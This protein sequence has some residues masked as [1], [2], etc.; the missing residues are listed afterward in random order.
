MAVSRAEIQ[1]GISLQQT[2]DQARAAFAFQR[3]KEVRDKG[4][5]ELRKGY[6]SHVEKLPAMIQTNGLGQTL[7]FLYSKGTEDARFVP[8]KKAEAR[9][10]Q[11]LRE[12][13]CQEEWPIGPYSEPVEGEDSDEELKLLCRL[14]HCDS[15]VYRRAT[16]EALALV[17]WLKRFAGGMLEKGE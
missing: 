10:Y 7:A 15:Q 1:A 3:M 9:L 4:G 6:R 13:L 8:D 2:L 5:P 12:W 14:T 17:S 16:V 11:H